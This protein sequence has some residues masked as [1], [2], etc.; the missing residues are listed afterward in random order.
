MYLQRKNLAE[1]G[2]VC[3]MEDLESHEA[4]AY[5][6]IKS[7]FNRLEMAEAKKNAKKK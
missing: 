5:T 2:Y 4:E 7:E 3:S 1:I 6:L